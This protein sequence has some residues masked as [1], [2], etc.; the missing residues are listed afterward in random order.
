MILDGKKLSVKILNSVKRKVAAK[1]LKIALAVI[2]VG[3]HPASLAYVRQKKLAAQKVGFAFRELSF[4]NSVSENFLLAEIEKLNQDP[5]IQGFI[6]QL[7][8][9]AKINSQKI[10]EKISPAKDVDGFH[11]LNLGKGFLDLP[12]LMPA[13]PAGILRLLDE[14]KIPLKGQNVVVVG[15][16]NIVGKPLAILL[17]NRDATVSVCHEFTKNLSEF[18][19]N[20]DVVISA[21]GVPK[22][23]KAKM[24]KKGVVLVDAGCAKVGDKLVG[25]V[26]FENV[27]KIAKA[28]TPVPGGVG[29]MTVAT[30]IE[31]TFKASQDNFK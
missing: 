16:S 3:K 9:P 12:A 30:L 23:I 5:K 22:L 21:T 8:L 20:A 25:D 24:L 19:K 17:I 14:Y 28:I 15:H 7:P 2:L 29:P 31:N 6:V 18:T 10:L 26:D 13:T 11:P 27:Q 1:K 4:P